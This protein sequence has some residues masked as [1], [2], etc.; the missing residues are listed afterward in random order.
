MAPLSLTLLG[1]FQARLGSG[2][3]LTLPAKTQ[4]L[5]AY[6]AMSP[7]QAHPREKLATLLWGDTGEEQARQSLRQALSG[8]R[9]ALGETAVPGPFLEGKTLALDPSWVDVDVAA[10]KRLVAEGTP[11]A[12]EQATALYRGDLLEGLDV[13]EPAFEEWLVSERER[14]RELGLE[15]LAKLLAHQTRAGV[16]EAAIQTAVRLLALDPLQEAVHRTLMRLYA[17]GGRRGAALRQYQLCVGVLQRE[18][19]VEPE[20]ETKQCYQEILQRASR[21][22]PAAAPQVRQPSRPRRKSAT[23]R[24][25]LHAPETPLIGREPELP[26]LRHALGEAWQ[27]RGQIVVILGEAGIGKSRVIEEIAANAFHQ[28]GRVLLGRCYE[29][30]QILPFGPWVDAIRTGRVIQDLQESEGLQPVWRAELARLFPA[31]GEPRPPLATA[32]ED[33]LRLFEAMAQLVEHLA[34]HQPLLL[35]LED[36]HWADEMSLRLLSFLGRQVRNRPVLV[37]GTAREEELTDAPVLRHFLQELHR[38]PSSVLLTLSPL[39][40]SDTLTLVKALARAGSEESAL[41]SLGQQ[42]WAVSE[43]NPFL[44]VETMRALHEGKPPQTPYGLPLPQRVREIIAGRLERLGERNR[45][46]VAVA[47]VIGREFDFALLARA[48]ELREREAA[49]GVEELVRRRVLHGVGEQF[50]FTHDRIREVAYHQLLPPRRKLLHGLVGRALE[51][52]YAE[53]LEPHYA[54]LGVHYREGEVWEKSL[55]YL[56]RAAAK[57]VALCVDRE[58]V[59]FYER[60]LEAVEHLP[61][62]PEKSGKAIDLRLEMRASLWRLGQL[63]QLFV[64]FQ[65]AEELAHRLGDPRRLH[66]IYAFLVQYYWAMG[67]QARA[68]EYGQRCLAA[69]DA[70]DDLALQVTGNLYIGHAY[71]ALGEFPKAVEY[72]TQNVELLEGGQATEQFGLSG[73]PYVISCAWAAESLAHLGEFER[74]NEFARRGTLVAQAAGHPYSLA[75]IRTS[76]GYTHAFK[77]EFAEAIALLEPTLRMCREKGFAGWTMRSAAALGLACALAGRPIEAIGLHEEAIRLKEES[78]ALVLRGIFW[79]NLG[80]A[81]LLAGR[82]EEARR[83]GEEALKFVQAHA[84]QATEP[85][86]RWVLGEV[87]ARQTPSE[88]AEAEA[89]LREAARLAEALGLRPMLGRC[90]MSLGAFHRQIGRLDAARSELSAAIELFRSMEM[91]SWL[92]RAEAELA[93][94]A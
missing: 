10:L 21:T 54:A 38:E 43:G 11:G 62:G 9:K 60:A 93:K 78:G 74:A 68:I 5:L 45:H 16:M 65:E 52:L 42:V 4:A 73:L 71:H 53:N 83:A 58:A 24:L 3:A 70:L 50:D 29:T 33:Y 35:I 90:L 22:L 17:G 81:L 86:S 67:E 26:R 51:E 40:Q 37:M 55:T 44:V 7:G 13:S 18:L 23:A 28:G 12:L 1:G 63:D 27:G 94:M 89:Q 82:A 64:R 20:P 79:A 56:R 77:G 6:L 15:A 75:A 30:E 46:L 32:G 59:G 41:E 36:L 14:L 76:T 85:W 87:A 19:G 2:P 69:A 31:L 48:A 49:E 72:L 84:E 34:A 92:T 25:E 88:H 8:L 57:A 61:E 66:K 47:A 80:E 91:T 39:S